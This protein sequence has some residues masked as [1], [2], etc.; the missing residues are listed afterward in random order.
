[1]NWAGPYAKI[2]PDLVFEVRSPSDRTP[3]VLAKVDEYLDAGVTVVCVVDESD[4]SVT[5]YR[6]DQDEVHLTGGMDF[7]AADVLPG[8]SAPVRKFFE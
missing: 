1:M 7:I 2:A 6:L 5:V 4:R 3:K 8:F